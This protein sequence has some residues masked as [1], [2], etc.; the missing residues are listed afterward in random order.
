MRTTTSRSILTL[1]AG[2]ALQLAV[3]SGA[4]ASKA[5]D[6]LTAAFQFQLP[7]FDRYFAGGREGFL[8]GLLVYDALIYRD[9]NTLEFKPLLATSWRQIDDLTLE[10]DLRQGVKF[11]NGDA[12]TAEDVVYTINF[13]SNP[14]NKIFSPET[15][16]W[17]AKAEAV[18]SHTV[19]ITAKETTPLALNYVMQ[20]AILPAKYHATVGKDEFGLRPVGTGPY[21]VA[22]GSGNTVVFARNE[23]YFT[24]GGKNKP[25]IG[26]LVYKTVPDVTAQVAEL[27]T[28]AVDWAYYIPSDLA[29]RMAT[30]PKL[31][32]TNADTFRVGFLTLNVDNNVP[33]DS[34]LRDVRVRRALNHAIDREKIAKSLVG[35]SAMVVNSACSP[36][37]FACRQDLPPYEYDPAKAKALLAEAGYPNGFDVDVFGYRSRPVAESI[38]GYLRAVNVRANLNWLQYPAVVKA[39]REGKAAIVIDDFGSSGVADAGYILSFFFGASSDDLSRD[40]EVTRLV[41]QGS[42]KIDSAGREKSYGD[43][44]K[45]IGER[46][47][48]VPLFTMPINYVATTDLEIPIPRDENVEFWRARW[49]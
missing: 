38:L 19:R 3:P 47:Y 43:A 25:L 36:L 35:S 29:A 23:A 44:L 21:T 6:T 45:L 5:D 13:V 15:A 40:K 46:A 48:W 37:Q 1:A 39:R 34:P 7:T 2:L 12:L 41:A 20:L 42:E 14:Q 16:A 24:G 17:I 49:K 18:N 8:L 31:R 9:P 30:N 26:K 32:I 11:H 28:G 10:F 33:P 22:K 27:M 4:Q